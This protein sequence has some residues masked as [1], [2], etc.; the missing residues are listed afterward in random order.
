M[1]LPHLLSTNLVCAVTRE[2]EHNFVTSSINS[3]QNYKHYKA[4]RKGALRIILNRTQWP[5]DYYFHILLGWDQGVTLYTQNLRNQDCLFCHKKVRF[6][7][8]HFYFHFL[9]LMHLSMKKLWKLGYFKQISSCCLACPTISILRRSR[10]LIGSADLIFIYSLV[11]TI[12]LYAVNQLV[13]K[14][15]EYQK[16]QLNLVLPPFD[17]RYHVSRSKKCNILFHSHI[18][19]LFWTVN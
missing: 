1:T 3:M 14:F 15:I 18:S 10:N 19:D 2:I 6:C 4:I 11:W 7:F 16:R 12:H 17:S 13:K 8:S 5:M 9:V